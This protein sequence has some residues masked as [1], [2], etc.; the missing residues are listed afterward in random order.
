MEQS[1]SWEGDSSSANQEFPSIL[2]NH[3]V[4]YRI[5][6]SPQPVP[7]PEADQSIL[8]RPILLIEEPF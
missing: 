2:W 8:R 4:H 3:K 6:N 7:C 5:H 1:P